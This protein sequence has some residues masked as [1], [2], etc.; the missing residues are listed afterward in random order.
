MRLVVVGAGGA[1]RDLLR[2]LGELWDVTILDPDPERIALAEKIRD[3][4]P[5]LGDGSSRVTMERAGIVDADALVVATN[6]DAVNLEAVKIGLEAGVVRIVAVAADP[7]RLGEYRDLEIPVFSPDSLAARRVEL[8]LEPR[9]ISST[10]FADGKAEAIEFRIAPD[11]AV[12]GKRLRELHSQSWVVAAVLRDNRLIVPHGETKLESGDLVTVVGA[13]A[14]FPAIVRVFTSG[15]A[16]FPLHFGRKVA[17]A[18]DSSGDAASVVEE[19]AAITRNSE[20]DVL[21]VVHADPAALRDEGQANEIAAVI[22]GLQD[23]TD[24]VDIEFRPT[25]ESVEEALIEVARDASVGLVTLSAP[26]RSALRGRWA[27]ARLVRRYRN[28]DVP[29]LLSRGTP[30]SRGLL[31]P[32]RRTEQ[33]ESA[34]RAAIDL[35]RSSGATLTGVAVV[36]PA[37]VASDTIDQARRDAAWMREEAAVQG[38]NVRRRVRRGNPVR[39]IEEMSEETGVLLLA[40]PVAPPTFFRPGLIGHMVR[41]AHCSVMLIPPLD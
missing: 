26:P 33:S 27:M 6:D 17:V 11:A 3:I 12:R 41:R 10:E 21:V 36:P 37:F 32:A 39:V 5:I 29:L 25:T 15:E 23:R 31:V 28:V 16:R 2:R 35:A 18:V 38:V 19:A 22:E 8:S 30:I 13:A 14:D 1:T 4:H 9:R 20:A 7:E 24:G 40:W 34:V